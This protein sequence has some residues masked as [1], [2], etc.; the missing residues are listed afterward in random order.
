MKK[1]VEVTAHMEYKITAGEFRPGEKL[2]SVREAA[3]LYECSVS[4]IVRAYGELQSRHLA[5]SIPQSGYY[6]VGEPELQRNDG[7]A[8]VIDFTSSSP[9]ITVFPYLDFQ[10]CLN[11]AIDTYKHNLFTYGEPQGME[12]LRRTLVSHLATD[13]VFAKMEHIFVTSGA[14]E[15]LAILARMPFPNDKSIILVEQPGYDKY[16]R[17]LEMKG[18]P[19][20]R[21]SSRA[22]A[23]ARPF[24]QN[25]CCP[26]FTTTRDTT[27][28]FCPRQRWKYTSKTVCTT[29]ISA[30]YF[31]DTLGVCTY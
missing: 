14:Q 19:V 10:R 3:Q 30:K 1:Y 18:I 8:D 25:S 11:Q 2:P 22:C 6:V 29:G 16:L 17:F 13:Q 24:Y 28:H 23:W 9:D 4:T 12:R 21:P 31:A 15:A 27:P 7:D 20:R 26:R 5:Y